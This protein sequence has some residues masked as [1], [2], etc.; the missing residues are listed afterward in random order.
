MIRND[1]V[2]TPG[3]ANLGTIVFTQPVMQNNLGIIVDATLGLIIYNPMDSTS[4]GVLVGSTLT[5]EYNTLACASNDVLQVYYSGVADNVILFSATLTSIGSTIALSTTGFITENIQISGSWSGTIFAETSNDSTHWDKCFV[6][7]INEPYIID[8][9]SENGTYIIR[10][11][12]VYVRLNVT[13]I[14]GTANVTIAGCSNDAPTGADGL[15]LALDTNSGVR[16]QVSLPQDFKQDAV[17]ALIPS[18]ASCVYQFISENAT[19]PMIIDTT[20][21]NSIVMQ[22]QTTGIITPTVSNDGITWYA[23][24]GYITTTVT[25]LI[26][27]TA[28]AG[29]STWPVVARYFKLTGPAS[30]TSAIIYLRSAQFVLPAVENIGYFGGTAPVTAGVG[31]MLAVGGNIATGSAPTAYPILT[32]GID[33]AGKTRTILTDTLGH[34]ISAAIAQDGTFQPLSVIKGSKNNSSALA[35]QNVEMIDNYSEIELLNLILKELR[36]LNTQ[37]NDL[38]LI[39]SKGL[40]FFPDDPDSYRNDSSLV[41]P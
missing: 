32:S 37:M 27:A 1:Y 29:I 2:F 20:G 41:N 3:A 30:V 26:T 6:L 9:I 7:P 5:L 21:Y 13:S 18:D 12:G 11:S 39:L 40:S 22:Q 36:V 14:T 23:A 25:S 33:T 8:K 34:P 17:G 15:S 16:V 31:G 24:S 38:P 10:D 4:G 28:A 19:S 35:I